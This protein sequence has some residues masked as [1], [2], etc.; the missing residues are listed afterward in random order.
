M[1]ESVLTLD[2]I[3]QAAHI[4]KPIIRKTDLIKAEG[5]KADCALYLKAENLQVTGSFKVRGAFFKLAALSQEEKAK[6]VI[7][8]SAGNHARESRSA[9]KKAACM[10][11]FSFQVPRR[12][13][14]SRRHA[15]TARKSGL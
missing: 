2:K 12:S 14:K 11:Q 9:R 15:V 1:E 8:C 3:Y 10:P 6:G 7:A 5:I 4:L 13:R